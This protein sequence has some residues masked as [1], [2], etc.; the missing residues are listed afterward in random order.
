MHGQYLYG[1]GVVAGSLAILWT[2][3]ARAEPKAG[4][5]IFAETGILCDTHDQVKALF[6]ATKSGDTMKI[7]DVYND[8]NAKTDQ[9]NEASCQMQPIEGGIAVSVEDMGETKTPNS[10]HVHA[11]LIEL[12]GDGRPNS[13]F[14]YGEVIDPGLRV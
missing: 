8:F 11:Y 14:L 1:L 4:A 12:K 10:Q 2:G 7:V 13:W 6:D 5:H 9:W 3:S